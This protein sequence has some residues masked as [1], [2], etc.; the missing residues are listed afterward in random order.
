MFLTRISV[1]YPVFATMMMVTVLV[2]GLFSYSRLGVDQF[3]ETNLPIVVV[4]ASYTGASP[5]TVA[6]EV[7]RPIESALNTIA[8]IN[9]ITSE[10]YEG[11]SVVV[12]Q[13]ELDIDSQIAAQEVRDRVARLE[14]SFPDEVD[15]PQITR[16]NPDDQPIL[17]VAASSSTRSLSDIT[18]LADRVI[19]N[20]LNV[21][22]GVGQITLVGGSERQMLVVVDPD[23]LEA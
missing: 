10:S 14:A 21:L 12:V 19:K 18:T 23:R 9:N 11:R 17:S 15:T 4:T 13:F 3:P 8:G 7:S 1:G 6:S 22:S 16:F 2:I 5:E 20:R